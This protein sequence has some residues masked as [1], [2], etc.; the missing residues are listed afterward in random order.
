MRA[1]FHGLDLEVDWQ[2]D[3]PQVFMLKQACQAMKSEL[4][5]LRKV[6][7]RDEYEPS[8]N[9]IGPIL[10]YGARELPMFLRAEYKIMPNRLGT[11]VEAHS[12]RAADEQK[13]Q[14][15]YYVDADA[16]T[17][18]PAPVTEKLDLMH[19]HVLQRMDLSLLAGI[20]Q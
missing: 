9:P 7:V 15:A 17:S 10:D 12:R 14:I 1:P 18:N 8:W 3:S 5:A 11:F 2:N 16:F 19:R 20:G 6:S 4:D 13:Y